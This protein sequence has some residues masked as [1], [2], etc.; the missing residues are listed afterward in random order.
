MFKILINNEQSNF[1]K[2]IFNVQFWFALEML[3]TFVDFCGLP[4][5]VV[6]GQVLPVSAAEGG[7]TVRTFTLLIRHS[8][9]AG[10]LRRSGRAGRLRPGGTRARLHQRLPLRSQ[11]DP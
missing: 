6:C 8:R 10:L 9:S 1:D 7:Y 5:F 11:S 3:A 4:C 2:S